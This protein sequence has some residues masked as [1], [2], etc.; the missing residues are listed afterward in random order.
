[1]SKKRN[2]SSP[3]TSQFDS[4]DVED[5][6]ARDDT[7]RRQEVAEE[8]AVGA[9]GGENDGAFPTFT[10]AAQQHT[11]A[12]GSGDDDVS[13]ATNDETIRTESDTEHASGISIRSVQSAEKTLE[14]MAEPG[15]QEQN[16]AELREPSAKERKDTPVERN[17]ENVTDTDSQ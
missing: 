3:T 8:P 12:H 17:V 2:E 14:E 10:P 5:D 4:R 11:T 16:D 1:M 6:S 15:V 13:S 9:S 7:G